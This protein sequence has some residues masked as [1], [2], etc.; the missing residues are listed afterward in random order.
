MKAPLSSGGVRGAA[1]ERGKQASLRSKKCYKFNSCSGN[2]YAGYSHIY[3]FFLLVL[4]F[5]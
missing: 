5:T 3:C 4:I 2:K 1:G